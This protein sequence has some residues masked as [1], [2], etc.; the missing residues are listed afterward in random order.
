MYLYIL[1]FLL[2]NRNQYLDIN[3]KIILIIIVSIFYY[4]TESR[5]R[6]TSTDDDDNKFK[7][8]YDRSI[9]NK[10]PLDQCYLGGNDNC[11]P[12]GN[13]CTD[14][15]Y[16]ATKIYRLVRDD[17][18]RKCF[19][20]IAKISKDDFEYG[21]ELYDK[22]KLIASNLYDKDFAWL[23]YIQR[24]SKKF[25]HKEWIKKLYEKHYKILHDKINLNKS[26][27][28]KY[29]LDDDCN[30]ILMKDLKPP[31]Y[32]TNRIEFK[33]PL[34][35]NYKDECPKDYS[36]LTDKYKEYCT[37]DDNSENRCRLDIDGDDNYPICN[38]VTCPSGYEFSDQMCINKVNKND[39]CSL[40]V[41]DKRG[42]KLCNGYNDFIPFK[43]VDIDEYTLKS[44]P[45]TNAKL[46]SM[47]CYTNRLC[48]GFTI[49]Q[50]KS[51]LTCKLKKKPRVISA[52][53][54][55]PDKI[56]YFRNSVNY[57]PHLNL[58]TNGEEIK[59][60][61]IN[62][63]TE[64]AKIC[65]KD[66][67]CNAFQ[68]NKN[69][70]ECKLKKPGNKVMV[71]NNNIL[72]KKKYYHGKLCDKLS[73]NEVN[74]D[75]K[76]H[77]DNLEVENNLVTQELNEEYNLKLDKLN[78][79][80]KK[81]ARSDIIKI[82]ANNIDTIYW[83]NIYSDCNNIIIK[84]N[85]NKMNI[86]YIQIVGYDSQRKQTY[87]NLLENKRVNITIDS[88]KY[89]NNNL[90]DKSLKTYTSFSEL[91]IKLDKIYTI[92]K[93]I[94][95][96][97]SND[98]SIYPL[99]II[100]Y[101]NK[102]I[103]KKWYKKNININEIISSNNT[104]FI[105]N[106]EDKGNPSKFNQYSDISGYNNDFCRFVK[107]DTEFCCK[108][109]NSTNE[110]DV[111]VDSNKI[112]TNYPKT[113]FFNKNKSSKKDD[114]CWCDG[115]EPNN[116]IKCI[117]S[118][119]NKFSEYYQLP[120]K[121]NNCNK[122]GIE[123]K[124]IIKYSKCSNA[125]ININCG[126]YWDKNSCYYLFNNTFFNKTP[127]ILF[128]IIDAYT[129]NVKRGYPQIVNNTTFPGLLENIH[130]NSILYDGNNNIYVIY[131][132]IYIKYNLLKRQKYKGY[133]KKIRTNFKYLY[134]IFES[135]ITN[136]VY[137]NK[138]KALIFN[139]L[140]YIYY[141]IEQIENTN[142]I[143]PIYDSV[144]YNIK[145]EFNLSEGNYNCILYNYIDNVYLFIARNMMYIKKKDKI[146]K[147]DLNK[148]FSNFWKLK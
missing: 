120:N 135:N 42:Y 43:E 22:I 145:E 39:K 148:K 6:F 75:I 66:I 84:N 81:K 136:S 57:I 147:F 37:E 112:S 69:N 88:N 7:I 27:T 95:Y 138:N 4:L 121:L 58:N 34:P 78:K 101:N 85:N 54:K 104:K 83:N 5:D 8:R 123:L 17:I 86:S 79:T 23:S 126:F 15:R 99:E 131:D 113:Y 116:Y 10:R 107:N 117:K 55:N 59:T 80:S 14:Y 87:T 130:I 108:K 40:D 41:R 9:C 12:D 30:P 48:D 71:D 61:D 125:P 134:S 73:N 143:N 76:K 47:E 25:P 127:I 133:P 109:P 26:I 35:L 21:K 11:R 46:C 144:I 32:T 94:I 77:L 2:L 74:E 89:I 1:L 90:L 103:I 50:N 140:K 82:Y 119:N 63:P 146:I 92:Y 124:N 28:N 142:D 67:N 51:N 52:I 106:V 19:E 110:Y 31:T 118:Q 115:L 96:N 98:K 64:C 49:D 60:Y 68:I 29:I 45:N 105:T 70:L 65:D 62:T 139:N 38:T 137:I 102:S 141:D 129:F 93:I 97:K 13:Y 111:C 132:N 122:S 3:K 72:F 114:L 33:P 16:Y 24:E 91:N 18:K 53:K 100:L 36:L 20:K 56:T 128:T 44:I